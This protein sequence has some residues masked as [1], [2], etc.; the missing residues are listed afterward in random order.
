MSAADSTKPARL[1]TTAEGRQNN[2]SVELV[3]I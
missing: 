2:R 3:K 1:N